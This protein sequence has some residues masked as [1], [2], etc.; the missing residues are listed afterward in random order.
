MR[1]TLIQTLSLLTMLGL[2]TAAHADRIMLRASVR[3]DPGAEVVHLADVATIEGEEA[4][5]YAGL[6]LAEVEGVEPIELTIR[7]IRA[8]LDDAGAHWGRINL[9]G[10]AVIVRPRRGVAV[11]D[12]VAMKAITLSSTSQGR[13]EFEPA[14]DDVLA[15]HVIE[16]LTLR[17][18]I[19]RS[20]VEA[21]DVPSM[22]VRLIFDHDDVDALMA[23]GERHRFELA[24]ESSLCSDRVTITARMW[25]DTRVTNTAQITLR[26]LVRID[27]AEVTRDLDRREMITSADVEVKRQ[28]ITPLRAAVACPPG[29]AIGRIAAR[30]LNTGDLLRLRDVTKPAVIERG[31]RVTVRCL[32][33]G[34]AISLQAEALADGAAGETIEMRK[35][36]ERE[37][38]I[39]TVIGPGEAVV[40]LATTGSAS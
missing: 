39:A 24:P 5:Q 6:V 10:R 38:F 11:S 9:N 35:L 3:L 33:G 34:V 31:D 20:I 27:T 22:D 23:S 29:Q 26:P 17:G 4:T 19:A 13:E 1:S 2:A 40:D 30:T 28:W 12:P 7:D 32:V 21:L 18:E 16:E 8:R 15:A 37:H 14:E 25:S 36:G